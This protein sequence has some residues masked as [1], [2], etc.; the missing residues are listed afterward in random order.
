[1]EKKIEEQLAEFKKELDQLK[2]VVSTL[3]KQAEKRIEARSR[4]R[5]LEARILEAKTKWTP[6][7]WFILTGIISALIALLAGLVV[8]V[9]LAFSY[10][11]PT[12]TTIV[13]PTHTVSTFVDN[14]SINV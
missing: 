13:E 3:D 10:V 5:E 8:A 14:N 2:E 12:T 11:P 1:M 4:E 7:D 9:V 6:K